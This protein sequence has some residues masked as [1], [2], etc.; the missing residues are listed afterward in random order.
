M[1][2]VEVGQYFMTKDTGDLETISLSGLSRVHPSNRVCGS[3]QFSI[4]RVRFSC[5]TIRICGLYSE[6]TTKHVQK[7]L[8]IHKKN[9]VCQSRQVSRLLGQS[10][11]KA[12]VKHVVDSNQNNNR[13]NLLI[14]NNYH[15]MPR[16]KYQGLILQPDQRQK[17]NLNREN[18]LIQRLPS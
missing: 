5:G 2:I 14:H 6:V 17:Q 18:L 16:K 13:K 15:T 9:Q 1:R 12:K 7:F 11:L 8:Q 3:R 10:Y 4:K